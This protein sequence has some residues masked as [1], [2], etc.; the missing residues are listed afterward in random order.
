MSICRNIRR[1]QSISLTMIHIS[2][3]FGRFQL[4]TIHTYLASISYSINLFFQMSKFK[5]SRNF[6]ISFFVST[7]CFVQLFFQKKSLA[8]HGLLIFVY[9][10][11]KFV[12]I[13]T[14]VERMSFTMILCYKYACGVYCLVA[15]ALETIKCSE[16]IL[17]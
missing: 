17:N 16:C 10:N 2:S 12:V 13:S 5:I 3:R 8:L 14:N 7:F 15:H 1:M 4:S 11:I 9:L 6:F